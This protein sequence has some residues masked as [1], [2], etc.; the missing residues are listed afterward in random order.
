M[1]PLIPI[2]SPQCCSRKDIG[3][4]ICERDRV[5]KTEWGEQKCSSEGGSR[6]DVGA[7]LATRPSH[8]VTRDVARFVTASR[9]GTT[10]GVCHWSASAAMSSTSH[11]RV[12]AV[13]P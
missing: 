12:N 9:H 6:L 3:L 8:L 1:R 10:T 13:S 11:P 4:C 2:L 5:R 7:A